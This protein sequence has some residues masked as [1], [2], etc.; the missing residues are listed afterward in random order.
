VTLPVFETIASTGLTDTLRVLVLLAA[1]PSPPPDIVELT[2]VEAGA[3]MATLN[4]TEM[5]G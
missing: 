3:L 4:V 2:E 5:A 1:L